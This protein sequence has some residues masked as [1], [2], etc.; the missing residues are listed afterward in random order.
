M[1]LKEFHVGG[2]EIK[3]APRPLAWTAGAV[4]LAAGVA[5]A[6]TYGVTG[7][8]AREV[9]AVVAVLVAAAVYGFRRLMMLARRG[10]GNPAEETV[11]EISRSRAGKP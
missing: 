7:T 9:W 1:G 5:S 8:D 10:A 11:V 2:Y 3:V 4:L 6:S